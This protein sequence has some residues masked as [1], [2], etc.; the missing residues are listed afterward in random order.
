MKY[1]I[2]QCIVKVEIVL[3]NMTFSP[4][5]VVVSKIVVTGP[6]NDTLTLPCNYTIHLYHHSMC[7]GRSCSLTSCNNQII[8]TDGQKVTWRKS[9][10]YQ[11]LGN[12]SQGDLSLTITGAT[13]EDEGTYC[14]RVEIPGLFN[15]IQKEMEMKIQEEIANS[16][17][18]A[19]SGIH[20]PTVEQTTKYNV[21]YNPVTLTTEITFYTSQGNN[22]SEQSSSRDTTIYVIITCVAGAIFLFAFIKVVIYICKYRSRKRTK[23]ER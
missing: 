20:F 4:A 10:R 13:K 22:T 14:C 16:S 1:S 18:T 17:G 19:N 6:V 15:D 7:W 8:W 5:V 21:A 2:F 12:I 11:L 23:T 3:L 9:D